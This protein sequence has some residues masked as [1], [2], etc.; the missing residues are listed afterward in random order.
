MATVYYYVEKEESLNTCKAKV[1]RAESARH[2]FKRCQRLL[3]R[4]QRL[5]RRERWTDI[6]RHRFHLVERLLHLGTDDDIPGHQVLGARVIAGRLDGQELAVQV[7]HGLLDLFQVDREATVD[8][9]DE[10]AFI[11]QII[12]LDGGAARVRIGQAEV[13]RS[14]AG[15]EESGIQLALCRLALAQRTFQLALLHH[16]TQR[17]QAG[18]VGLGLFDGRIDFLQILA[19]RRRLAVLL[20]DVRAEAVRNFMREDVGEEGIEVEI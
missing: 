11:Q 16:V 8:K 14:E 18:D 3:R 7:G 12:H 10:A 5:G 2:T 17:V 4:Q 15:G 9:R 1:A 20:R 13:Q 19:R 6:V